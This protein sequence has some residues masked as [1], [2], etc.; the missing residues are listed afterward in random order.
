MNRENS[1]VIPSKIVVEEKVEKWEKKKENHSGDVEKGWTAYMSSA[2][3]ISQTE[4]F[5]GL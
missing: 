4:T 5:R 2:F 1:T 3:E